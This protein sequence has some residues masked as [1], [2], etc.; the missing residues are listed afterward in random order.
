MVENEKTLMYGSEQEGRAE[1]QK[2]NEA[3]RVKQQAEIVVDIET[4]KAELKIAKAKKEAAKA[5]L[6][7]L[8][9][10]LKASLKKYSN[11]LP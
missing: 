11:K 5:E 6:E 7:A 10:E 2:E 4:A 8:Q 9:A 3:V 1:G